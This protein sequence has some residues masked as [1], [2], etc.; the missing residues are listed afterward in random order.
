[1][2]DGSWGGVHAVSLPVERWAEAGEDAI[3][4]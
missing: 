3:A 4:S 2:Q 1:M